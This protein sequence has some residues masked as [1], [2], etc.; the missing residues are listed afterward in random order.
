MKEKEEE[1]NMKKSEFKRQIWDNK[2]GRHLEDILGYKFSYND[3]QYGV[4]NTIEN[5]FKLF[6]EV[7]IMIFLGFGFLRSFLKHYSWTSIAL[8]LMAGVLS[9]EFGLF[10]LIC[11]SAIFSTEWTTGN[12]NFQHLF[13]WGFVRKII[14]TSIYNFNS[15]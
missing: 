1:N 3:I 15:N 13:T 10:M 8:T 4:Y 6:Q 12:F 11:W 2:K 14:V 5:K 7:N 9:T